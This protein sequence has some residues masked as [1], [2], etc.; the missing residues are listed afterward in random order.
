[1]VDQ[2]PSLAAARK[3]VKDSIKF[4]LDLDSK[5]KLQNTT[6]HITVLPTLTRDIS[7]DGVLVV[8]DERRHAIKFDEIINEE[9][10]SDW[11]TL[12]LTALS[13]AQPVNKNLDVYPLSPIWS[14]VYIHKISSVNK[15]V[16]ATVILPVFEKE[17]KDKKPWFAMSVLEMLETTWSPSS[18]QHAGRATGADIDEENEFAM[19]AQDGDIQPAV[20]VADE[21]NVQPAEE[22][23]EIKE[24][25]IGFG[26]GLEQAPLP[27]PRVAEA[28][29]ND[30]QPVAVGN[31]KFN[32][33]KWSF[34]PDIPHLIWTEFF[35]RAVTLT[36]A[37]IPNMNSV[38]SIRLETDSLVEQFKYKYARQLPISDEEVQA[39]R[40]LLQD[41]KKNLAN[42]VFSGQ[43]PPEARKKLVFTALLFK[44]AFESSINTALEISDQALVDFFDIV[45]NAPTGIFDY[46]DDSV[47]FYYL[48]SSAQLFALANRQAVAEQLGTR[49]LTTK[50][51]SKSRHLQRLAH[52]PKQKIN[53]ATVR[54][55]RRRHISRTAR[56]F[57]TAQLL[58]GTAVSF[59]T[60]A[61]ER[62]E[63]YGYLVLGT[64][65]VGISL[66]ATVVP[67]LKKK[68]L[69]KETACLV[70]GYTED[71]YK[72]HVISQHCAIQLVKA[73]AVQLP[74]PNWFTRRKIANS[75]QI[76]QD[77]TPRTERFWINWFRKQS[78]Y[79]LDIV[80]S[81]SVGMPTNTQI[82]IQRVIGGYVPCTTE[83]QKELND[84]WRTAMYIA[85]FITINDTLLTAEN[86]TGK[87]R[88]SSS[89]W[90]TE[91]YRDMLVDTAFTGEID[92][93]AD[94]LS[95]FGAQ[96]LQP[97]LPKQ[98]VVTVA[99]TARD[100]TWFPHF[101]YEEKDT[102]VLLRQSESRRIVCMRKLARGM[103]QEKKDPIGWWQGKPRD[104]DTIADITI[105]QW[106]KSTTL[107]VVALTTKS[108]F[109]D[110]IHGENSK[111]ALTP[112]SSHKNIT[113]VRKIISVQPNALVKVFETRETKDDQPVLASLMR[114]FIRQ[115]MAKHCTRSAVVIMGRD[116]PSS[117][118]EA[119]Q[120]T[121]I[122]AL[123]AGSYYLGWG[124]PLTHWRPVAVGVAT[125]GVIT[126]INSRETQTVKYSIAKGALIATVF[127]GAV[128]IGSYAVA[129]PMA[130]GGTIGAGIGWYRGRSWESALR[131]ATR[132]ATVGLF[133]AVQG[134]VL[135][136]P[137]SMLNPAGLASFLGVVFSNLAEE[138][139]EFLPAMFGVSGL[140][141]G[142][143][144]TPELN[145]RMKQLAEFA[146]LPKGEGFE[147]FSA[148]FKTTWTGATKNTYRLVDWFNLTE[149][150]RD[151]Y[152]V[153]AVAVIVGGL[154]AFTAIPS[155]L[156]RFT[157][158][159]SNKWPSLFGFLRRPIFRD[160]DGNTWTPN[161]IWIAA[162]AL[163]LT[164]AYSGIS[165]LVNPDSQLALYATLPLN[166]LWSAKKLI[167]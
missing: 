18:T 54:N 92:A 145:R 155:L 60:M 61:V 37:A 120:F 127:A 167:R 134:G 16:S 23:K 21:K 25:E 17:E 44:R 52:T 49:D 109:V 34:A 51:F 126:A 47:R 20:A 91:L 13:R 50:L 19:F 27:Q 116:E 138:D 33:A 113:Q 107:V 162:A 85:P 121:G 98:P 45:G 141:T 4:A 123:L 105:L 83:N 70:E 158:Y 35:Q 160:R 90:G 77:P 129:G 106:Q 139:A 144:D 130:I 84:L 95:S 93:S 108:P 69:G 79:P 102:K 7:T 68:L 161:V 41:G 133:S 112:N 10:K 11:K 164:V 132:G 146:L 29:I 140:I 103:N 125:A 55:Q 81:N 72:D 48:A 137:V 101:V 30:N 97:L 26:L 76:E 143:P 3:S 142:R 8:A 104:L 156:E 24:P 147:A 100:E 152:G 12:A 36:Q 117:L 31:S 78:E 148:T 46:E 22:K 62:R 28:V 57:L 89:L 118:E 128:A 71:N 86:R 1:M 99:E 136:A 38:A 67:Y 88:D 114:T 39:C 2:L 166:F 82:C 9:T 32:T 159:L 135:N 131:Y 111:F 66:Q 165:D 42:A 153:P 75:M 96:M 124:G 73:C 74:E 63:R 56:M 80:I 149:N 157:G 5:A 122:A 119:A 64:F 40:T 151:G 6:L 150:C 15:G 65:A 59:A 94:I 43:M 163:F 14:E 53:D 115:L 58:S 154:I 110:L 87:N